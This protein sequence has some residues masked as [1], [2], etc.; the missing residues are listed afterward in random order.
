LAA[1][2]IKIK[3]LRKKQLLRLG[4]TEALKLFYIYLDLLSFAKARWLIKA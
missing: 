2:G 1:D 3:H 4:F